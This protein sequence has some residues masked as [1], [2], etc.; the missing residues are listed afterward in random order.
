MLLPFLAPRPT[1]ADRPDPTLGAVLD[2]GCGNAR[3]A[4][5]LHGAELRFAYTGV[6][7]N[8]A[9]LEAAR[10]RLPPALA[11]AA[12]L[13]PI[14]FLAGPNPGR[15]LPEG[16]FALVVLMGILHHV[17][18]ADGRL[19]LLREAAR[20]LA[21]G[22]HLALAA[23]QFED[24]PRERRKRVAVGSL[25][26]VLGEALDPGALE[27]GDFLLR[28]GEDPG[29]PPRYCHQ[30]AD[31]EFAGWPAALGLRCLADYRAD[32][33]RGDSNRYAILCHP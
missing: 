33:P 32:G 31:A 22:G 14:D 27:P 20:R 5:F 9:L 24:D 26:P 3:F 1:A 6:D 4:S 13:L 30:V 18:G 19:A 10:Q 28:F 16:P 8:A 23:W 11:P 29:A 2:I 15:N 17:P 7:A 25:A 21:P 12:R